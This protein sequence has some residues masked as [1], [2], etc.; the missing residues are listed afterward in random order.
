MVCTASVLL[1]LVT[2]VWHQGI[3]EDQLLAHVLGEYVPFIN[4]LWPIFIF[5]LGYSTI[6]AIFASGSK[7]AK[8]LLP[9]NGP[10]LYKVYATIVLVVFSFVGTD[11]QIMTFMSTTGGLLLAL[12]L[13]AIFTLR[14]EIQFKI[15]AKN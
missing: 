7:A 14:K 4:I 10:F 15:P 12:N 8:F 3:P 13:W 2:N 1:I 11:S 6:L 5:M 9:K